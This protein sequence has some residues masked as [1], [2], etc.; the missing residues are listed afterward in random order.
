MVFVV[1]GVAVQI[2]S[3]EWFAFHTSLFNAISI[4]ALAFNFMQNVPRLYFELEDRTPAKF[5][6]TAALA[7]VVPAVMYVAVGISGYI[8]VGDSPLFP[9]MILAATVY[10]DLMI[11]QIDR[12]FLALAVAVTFPFVFHAM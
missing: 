1:C 7:M 3:F 9:G 10:D 2:S 11:A 5:V 4:M 12:C 6:K 8:T